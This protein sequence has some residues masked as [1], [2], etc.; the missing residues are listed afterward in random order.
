MNKL[1][2]NRILILTIFFTIIITSFFY[3]NTLLPFFIGLFIAYILSPI[4]NFFEKKKINRN[5]ASTLIL[6]IFFIFIYSFTFLIIPIIVE[7][8][9]K[10]LEKFPS[11]LNKIEFQ[12][13]KISKLINNKFLDINYLDFLKSINES[14]GSFFKTVIR[15]LFFSS[16]AIVNLLSFIIVTPIVAWYFLKDWSKIIFFINKNIPIKY[17]NIVKKNL[18]EVDL[19]LAG[20]LRGQFLVSII[21]G[22]YYFIIFHLIGIDYSLFL[23]VFSGVFSL[24]PY[25][26]IFISFILSAYISLL[27]FADPL[28]IFYIMI[29]FFIAFLLEG[30][31]LSPK[32]IGEKLG[33][34]PLAILYSVF[35]FGSLLGFIGIFFAIPFASIIFLYYRK[36][37]FNINNIADETTSN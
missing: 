30:Y 35:L 8:T 15:K 4:V 25:F 34:H 18:K 2:L 27:Q 19:I 5:L 14:L 20:F 36:I 21:L 29:I 33:L 1:A 24:I 32:I 13:S 31:F 28:Y 6:I 22:F 10:F 7:Q 3:F 17:Q 12:I 16:L 23:G 11:L 26:G 9:V 37:L